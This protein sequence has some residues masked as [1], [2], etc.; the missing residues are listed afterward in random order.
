MSGFNKDGANPQLPFKMMVS[1]AAAMIL[2]LGPGWKTDVD[3]EESGADGI[4]SCVNC[5]PA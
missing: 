5:V 2:L 4:L 1:P 3:K